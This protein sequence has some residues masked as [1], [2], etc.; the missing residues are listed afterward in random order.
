MT[1]TAAE[2]VEFPMTATPIPA[3]AAVTEPTV[4]EVDARTLKA[5]MD[6]G[7]ALLV[8]VREIGEYEIERIAGAMLMPLSFFDPEN[9]PVLPGK[10]LV[11]MCAIGKRSTAAARQLLNAGFAEATNLKGGINAWK[12][13]GLPTETD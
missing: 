4:L 3:P 7:E 9:F 10:K 13:A 1:A 6:A 8:D 5:W 11:L 2:I 12:D